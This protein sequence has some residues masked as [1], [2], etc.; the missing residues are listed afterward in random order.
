MLKLTK[1]ILIQSDY[2]WNLCSNSPNT[3]S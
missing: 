1:L 2:W 3:V